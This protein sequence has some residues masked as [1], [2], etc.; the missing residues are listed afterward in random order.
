MLRLDLHV[1]TT[2]SYDAFCTVQAAVM[3]AKARGLNGIAI[4]DHNSISAHP[5]VKKFSARDFVIIPGV[6]ISSAD[7]HILAL[8]ISELIPR[9]LPAEE[10]AKRIREQGG[11]AIAAHPFALGR[12][13]GLVYKAK[14]DAIEA[15][16]SRAL[17]ISNPLA[18]RFAKKHKIPM[19]AGS[20]SH[21][22]S[23]IGLAYTSVNCDLKIDSIL[24]AVKRGGTS[25]SGHTLP[26]PSFLWRVLQKFLH[27]Q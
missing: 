6:E 26:L 14:F 13:P 23:E 9:S 16:N 4:T 24:D 1:H 25:I 8:G 19:T 2:H 3:A 18:L 21:R 20:D 15:L 22:C 17:F 12:K 10:T 27:K 5:E 11:I 7:G